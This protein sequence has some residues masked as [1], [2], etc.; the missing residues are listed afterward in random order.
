MVRI[1]LLAVLTLVTTGLYLNSFPGSFHYDDYPLLLE[2]PLITGEAF[3]LSTF[4][5]HY[6][7]RPLTLAT[8]WIEY[9]LFG[10]DP[11]FFH[12]V[13]YLLHFGM[14]VLLFFVVRR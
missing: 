6:R 2:N 5:S 14:V 13:N 4:W 1:V 9:S 10:S 11:L 3:P 7:G 8:I 12:L